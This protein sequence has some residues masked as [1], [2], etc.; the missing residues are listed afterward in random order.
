ML[1][2]ELKIVRDRTLAELDVFLAEAS[3]RSARRWACDDDGLAMGREDAR[4]LA[5]V[6]LA[7]VAG[8][9]MASR[10]V[11]FFGA[12]AVP[13]AVLALEEFPRDGG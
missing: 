6:K 2:V 1:E 3:E 12:V 13:P 4:G 5:L 9:H 11:D 10:H 7:G 8:R